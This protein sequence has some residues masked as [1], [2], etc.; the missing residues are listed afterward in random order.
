MMSAMVEC[1]ELHP[2]FPIC[3]VRRSASAFGTAFTRIVGLPPS[4]YAEHAAII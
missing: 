2:P 4:K 3:A 1:R